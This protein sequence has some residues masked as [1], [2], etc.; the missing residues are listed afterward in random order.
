[1]A[2]EIVKQRVVHVLKDL[3]ASATDESACLVNWTRQT[4]DP[5][6]PPRTPSTHQIQALF[7]AEDL[8]EVD[9]VV[10]AQLL[11][12]CGPMQR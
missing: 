6:H 2:L 7:S 3:N 12:R 1:M 8:N 9:E 5:A 4:A 10:V 11:S